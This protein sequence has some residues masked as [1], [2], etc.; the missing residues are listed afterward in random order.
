[1]PTIHE[2][3][4]IAVEHHEAGR[5]DAAEQ[6]YRQIL[7]LEE[8]N[9]SVLSNLGLVFRAGRRFEAALCCFH[10]ALE[11]QPAF[12]EAH[13]NLGTVFESQ[14]KLEKAIGCYRRAVE[15]KPEFAEAYN[16]LGHAL[17]ATGRAEEAIDC[18]S[19]TLKL[20][21]NHA[22]AHCNLAE[23]A[24]SQARFADA[25]ELCRQALA[26]KPDLAEAHTNLGTVLMFEGEFDGAAAS[27]DHALRLQ[28]DHPRT[29]TNRALLRLLRGNFEQGWP[30]YEWRWKM[31]EMASPEFTQPQWQGENLHGRTIM[32]WA[33]Q[34]LGDTF[35]FI[36]Y[37]GLLK[38]RGAIVV[39][40]CQKALTKVLAGCRGVDRLVGRGDRLPA[41]DFHAP[42][43][44]LPAIFETD[45]NNLPTEI[46][47][48]LADQTLVA[49][50]SQR[51]E[52]VKA[53]RIGINW[54][55]REGRGAFRKRDIPLEFFSELAEFPGV[56]LISLQKGAARSELSSELS[57]F[58]PG[59]DFDQSHGPFM[60]TA[61]I[62]RNVDLVITSDTSVPHLAGALGVPV[63]VALPLVA[64]WRW[65]LDRADSPWYP[66]M[67]L[68][69]QRSPGDWAGVFEKINTALHERLRQW[70]A[71]GRAMPLN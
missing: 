5:L 45:L 49:N 65:L 15:L 20:D 41:F 66:T 48:L 57:I 71:D 36:R 21:P 18:F 34:G 27:Y 19:R 30:E 24:L 70:N 22:E 55:G 28:P 51:L 29:H 3:L 38:E 43:L 40:Q 68:F 14:R 62:M 12:A 60:D 10:R 39:A 26:L 32:I 37:A 58:D 1:M 56:R 25:A 67:R 33:E 7:A 59:Q 63:W 42:L 54:S 64:D 52:P 13:N 4:A 47:Y 44:S 16:N 35:Q 31:G 8:D 46:P 2:A 53:F 69:R 23:V 6:I 50:W 11:L 9:A 61:A 17:Q